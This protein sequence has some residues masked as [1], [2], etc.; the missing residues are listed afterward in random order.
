MGSKIYTIKF[1]DQIRLGSGSIHIHFE[2]KFIKGTN[3]L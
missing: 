2:L 1:K 3:F